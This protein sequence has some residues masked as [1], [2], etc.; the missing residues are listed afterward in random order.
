MNRFPFTVPEGYFENIGTPD[1]LQ[2]V[3]RRRAAGQMVRRMALTCVT[4][5]AAAAVAVIVMLSPRTADSGYDGNIE[6]LYIEYLCSDLIPETVP[7][8]FYMPEEFFSET[9]E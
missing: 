4:V 3:R 9:S 5:A 8:A 1:Y 6:E 2:K 7:D